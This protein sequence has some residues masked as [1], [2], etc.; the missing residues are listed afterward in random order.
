MYE[1]QIRTLT[2]AEIEKLLQ[3]LMSKKH[4]LCA[5]AVFLMLWG[6]VRYNDLKLLRWQD[7]WDEQSNLRLPKHRRQWLYELAYP[8]IPSAP[9]LPRGWKTRWLNLKQ[10]LNIADFD[11]RM[12]RATYRDAKHLR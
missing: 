10:E 1:H 8:G 5:A 12:L 3:L 6:G 9:I 2:P 4:R 11:A 7:L